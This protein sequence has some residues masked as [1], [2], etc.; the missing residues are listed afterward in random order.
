M[1]TALLRL[2]RPLL[3]PMVPSINPVRS[4]T[5]TVGVPRLPGVY[6]S[7]RLVLISKKWGWKQLLALMTTKQSLRR[8]LQPHILERP[9]QWEALLL[10]QGQL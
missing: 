10:R 6:L 4:L 5:I 7:H 8:L 2:N 1:Y 3:V 9:P